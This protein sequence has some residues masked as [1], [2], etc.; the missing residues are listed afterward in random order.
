MFR[1]VA[2]GRG[3]APVRKVAQGREVAC[4]RE[5]V[6]MSPGI[7]ALV[8]RLYL[9]LQVLSFCVGN[10]KSFWQL[11]IVFLAVFW[12]HERLRLQPRR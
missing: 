11:D 7:L 6:S 1:E 10:L 4:G 8:T 3:V 2:S 5:L 9:I 12:R